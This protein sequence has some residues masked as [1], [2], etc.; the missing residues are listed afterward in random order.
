[1]KKWHMLLLVLPGLLATTDCGG[2]I[3]TAK[4][5][6]PQHAI[7]ID[8]NTDDWAGALSALNE[9]NASVGFFNDQT[10]LYACLV[11]N[12]DSSAG[13]M[14]GQSLT[15]WFDPTGGD[16]K[17]FGIKV[18]SGLPP[19]DTPEE[20]PLEEPKEERAERPGHRPHD[21]AQVLEILR[22]GNK[23]PEKIP[24]DLA[25]KEGIEIKIM[26]SIHSLVYELKVP[27]FASENHPLAIGVLEN[28]TIGVGFET[29]S[30]THNG[31]MRRPEGG[32]E[33]PDEE[34]RPPMEGGMRGRMG[35]GRGR[36]GMRPEMPGTQKA[37]K[38]WTEVKLS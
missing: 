32:D 27:L 28:R 4:S 38:I 30:P 21:F 34:G 3:Y 10:Y 7:A 24:I 9:E 17:T 25:N 11:I 22:A 6:I 18:G 29:A 19:T 12:R 1:M 14:M 35:G 37:L 26:P 13:P 23:T 2:T 36:P 20:E 15:V 33:G 8:G 5:L 16:R 31:R